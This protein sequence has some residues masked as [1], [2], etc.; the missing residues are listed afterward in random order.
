MRAMKDLK[1][2][3]LI[4]PSILQQFQDGFSKFTGLAALTTDENGTP[5]TVGSGFTDF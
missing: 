3:D 2:I 5:V 4:S 1:L